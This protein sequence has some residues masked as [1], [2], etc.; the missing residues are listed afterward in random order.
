MGGTNYVQQEIKKQEYIS[1]S[2]NIVNNLYSL[3]LVLGV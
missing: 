3:V 2:A 1:Q